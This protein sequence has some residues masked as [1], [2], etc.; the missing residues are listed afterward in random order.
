M[1]SRSQ[2]KPI[3]VIGAL[4]A[5]LV[6]AASKLVIALITRSSALL[7]ESFHSFVDTGNEVFLLIGIHQSKKPPDETHPFGYG[8]ELYFWS[9]IVAVM[10]FGV[11]GGFAIYEGITHLISPENARDALWNYIVLGIAAV[12]ES[13]S[14]YLGVKQFSNQKGNRNMLRALIHSR[15]PSLVTVIMENTADLLG[16]LIAFLGIFI[17]QRLNSSVPD[18]IASILIGLVLAVIAVFLISQSRALLVG[19]SAR[20]SVLRNLRE[21]ALSIPEVTSVEKL[22]TMQLGPHQILLNMEVTFNKDL[23]PSDIGRLIDELEQKI[24]QKYPEIQE[25]FVDV[26]RLKTSL[27]SNGKQP[28]D[29]APDNLQNKKGQSTD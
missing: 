10:L 13:I 6:I 23:S 24:Q 8:K 29:V 14:F 3:A 25:V 27:R 7:S 15:D 21:T 18:G 4:I 11:G 5:N 26:A 22:L 1:A 16:I 19:E 12:F 17:S 9:L 2:E 28:A 20:P